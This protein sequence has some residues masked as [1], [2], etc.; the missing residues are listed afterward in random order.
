MEM[1]REASL[2]HTPEM[3]LRQTMQ[4]HPR[5]RQKTILTITN[6]FSGTRDSEQRF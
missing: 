2:T 6:S 5:R 4:Q 3:L 1:M